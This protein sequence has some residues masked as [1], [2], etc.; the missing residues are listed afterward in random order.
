MITIC[1]VITVTDKESTMNQRRIQDIRNKLRDI[2]LYI[3]EI[4][5]ELDQAYEHLEDQ[6]EVQS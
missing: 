3:D 5:D 2:Q 1:Y 4:I 6:K